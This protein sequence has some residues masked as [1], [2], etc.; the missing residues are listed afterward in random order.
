MT[1]S[2]ELFVSDESL[3]SENGIQSDACMAFAEDKAVPVRV[4]GIHRVNPHGFIIKD[5]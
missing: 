2:F 4:L 5:C 1:I 3:V